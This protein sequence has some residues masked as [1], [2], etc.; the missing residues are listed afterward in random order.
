MET[1]FDFDKCQQFKE[2]IAFRHNY[3]Y[4]RLVKIGG[5]KNISE[6]KEKIFEKKTMIILKGLHISKH[7]ESYYQ[8]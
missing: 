4:R 7:R 5:K 8:Q 3:A 6:K 1:C 2:I